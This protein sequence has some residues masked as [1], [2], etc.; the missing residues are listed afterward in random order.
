MWLSLMHVSFNRYHVNM[1]SNAKGDARLL[2]M[3]KIEE[4]SQDIQISGH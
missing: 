4:L 2:L 3:L 1:Q